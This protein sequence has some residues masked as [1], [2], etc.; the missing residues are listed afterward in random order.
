MFPVSSWIFFCARKKESTNQHQ[1]IEEFLKSVSP[2]FGSLSDDV[3]VAARSLSF[4]SS[5]ELTRT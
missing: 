5:V 4:D 1:T 2:P 3:K